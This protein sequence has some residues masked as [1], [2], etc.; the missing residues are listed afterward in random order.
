[1]ASCSMGGCTENN[2]VIT[3]VLIRRLLICKVC[4]QDDLFYLNCLFCLRLW[5]PL[6]ANDVYVLCLQF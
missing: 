2:G 5:T 6:I 3:Q 4:Q 1:M